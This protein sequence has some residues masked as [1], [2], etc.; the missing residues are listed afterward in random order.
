MFKIQ[1]K[2][3]YW[4]PVLL[5][6][7]H[8]EEAGKMVEATIHVQYRWLDIDEHAAF[9]ADAAE[10]SLS[11]RDAM[12]AVVECF[13]TFETDQ[14]PFA[15]SAENLALLLKQPGAATAV[16]RA[17]FDSRKEAEQKN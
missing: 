17:Y 13:R 10:K 9:M 2:P 7:P 11:D 5:R 8:P 16:A 14:G 15:F 12:P 1:S 3:T 4:W 6:Q